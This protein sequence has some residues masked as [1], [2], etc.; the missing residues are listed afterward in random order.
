MKHDRFLGHLFQT[1]GRPDKLIFDKSYRKTLWKIL[2]HK[3][4]FTDEQSSNIWL[5]ASGAANM[6]NMDFNENYYFLMRDHNIEYPN[7][8]F[9]QIELDLYR[10]FPYDPPS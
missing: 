4:K 8:C 3:S 9:N 1:E 10:T 2:L 5:I 6:L 7:P